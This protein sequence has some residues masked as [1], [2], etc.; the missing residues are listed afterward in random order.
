MQAA[1]VDVREPGSWL[2]ILNRITAF[3]RDRGAEQFPH[4]HQR[5]LYEHLL[6]T[7][8]ILS[9]WLQPASLQLAGLLHSIYA[10][11]KYHRQLMEFSRRSEVQEL[12]GSDA[13]RLAFLFCVTSRSDFWNQ[14][15]Q[16]AVVGE[17]GLR[18]KRHFGGQEMGEDVSREDVRSLIVLHMANAADQAC[19]SNG[20]PG[21]WLAR[22]SWMGSRLRQFEGPLPPV[23][24][25]CMDMI[26]DVEEGAA[27][28]AYR[29]GVDTVAQNPSQAAQHFANAAAACPHVA[30]PMIWM[31]Y[32]CLHSGDS[33]GALHYILRARRT[34]LEWGVPWDKRLD[35]RGWMRFLAFLEQASQDSS[36]HAFRLSAGIMKTVDL[37]RS[38]KGLESTDCEEI[39]ALENSS[40]CMQA[41]G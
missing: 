17:T 9:R 4:A 13:E 26:N 30:E 34:L 23:F 20:A 12:A 1:V 3:L 19:A 2:C 11:D 38:L 37:Y 36:R 22:A 14:L 39:R 32:T 16:S 35:F 10:T 29:K 40:A 25:C 21:R 15:A 27:R 6:G 31:A 8:E 18:I 33:A 7:G 41:G 5:A 28:D 24:S